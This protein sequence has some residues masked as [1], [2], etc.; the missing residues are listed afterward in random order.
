M[1]EVVAAIVTVMD[2]GAIGDGETDDTAA[3]RL[4]AAEGRPVLVP[5]TAEGYVL[6]GTVNLVDGSVF[7]GEPGAR[8][9]I[10]W[11]SASQSRIFD[12]QGREGCGLESLTIDGNKELAP[13]GTAIRFRD[14]EAAFIRRCV[15]IDLPG[16]STGAVVL[17]GNSWLCVIE[18]NRFITPGGTGLGLSGA[19]VTLN[20]VLHNHFEDTGNFGVRQGEGATQNLIAF[21]TGLGTGLEVIA[22]ATGAARSRIIG[23]HAENSGDNGISVSADHNA[24]VGNVTFENAKAGIGVWGSF[25][26]VGDN[27]TVANEQGQ[28][29][30]WGGIWIANGYGCTGQHNAITGNVADDP[31]AVKTQSY[32]IRISGDAYPDW[33]AAKAYPAGA[34]VSAGPHVYKAAV[35]GTSGSVA[36]SHVSGTATDG[37]VQWSYV[38]SH[39]GVA[40]PAFNH[41]VGNQ[42][43]RARLFGVS[44]SGSW[45]QNKAL[46]L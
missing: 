14:C 39:L 7:Y 20:N 34:Y 19:G 17:S 4:A 22:L 29:G 2:Y 26:A 10:R 5:Y 18:G 23:N 45:A 16:T 25:N 41:L 21:N 27:V 43:P 35:G 36:P 30:Y 6:S 38:A 31:Q 44:D 8:A 24:V 1:G 12:A 11:V 46:G 37:T 13:V 3:F 28:A 42:T 15:L 33:Q 40:L 9:L 32:G